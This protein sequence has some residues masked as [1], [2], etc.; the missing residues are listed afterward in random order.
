[1]DRKHL[2]GAIGSAGGNGPTLGLRRRFGGGVGSQF[3]VDWLLDQPNHP[4]RNLEGIALILGGGD[5]GE[6][7]GAVIVILDDEGVSRLEV[8]LRRQGRIGSEGELEGL[9][10]GFGDDIGDHR[11]GEIFLGLGVREGNGRREGEV[12]GG[13]HELREGAVGRLLG[14][15]DREGNAVGEFRLR[16]QGNV[17]VLI[18]GRLGDIGG[19]AGGDKAGGVIVAG[20]GDGMDGGER[21]DK[22]I[23]RRRAVNGDDDIDLFVNLRDVVIDN[24]DG[25]GGIGAGGALGDGD[26]RGYAVELDVGRISGGAGFKEGDG[27]L[28]AGGSGLAQS[29]SQCV[30]G[31][32]AGIDGIAG[33]RGG[34]ADVLVRV[35]DGEGVDELADG[36]APDTRE[37][38]GFGNGDGHYIFDI[39]FVLG[40]DER[41]DRIGGRGA[42]RDGIDVVGGVP[43]GVVRVV[44]DGDIAIHRGE[45]HHEGQ[46][47]GGGGGD[48]EGESD[49]V[50]AIGDMLIDCAFV[51][52]EGNGVVVGQ[53]G[54]GEGL[55]GIH[56]P[57]IDRPSAGDGEGDIDGL[58][59]FRA[60]GGV[61]IDNLDGDGGGGVSGH[62]VFGNGD[63]RGHAIETD[64]G[65]GVAGAGFG[66]G[67]GKRQINRR[68]LGEG[69][70]KVGG[71]AFAG[72]VQGR[73][74]EADGNVVDGNGETMGL[75][76]ADAPTGGGALAGVVQGDRVEGDGEGF[77]LLVEVVLAD[78]DGE[79]AGIRTSDGIGGDAAAHGEVIVVAAAGD[80]GG[81]GETL[82]GS[83]GVGDQ[84]ESDGAALVGGIRAG[85]RRGGEL[86]PA[87][88]GRDGDGVGVTTDDPAGG[89]VGQSGEGKDD[90]FG[91]F[92][93]IIG[94]QSDRDGGASSGGFQN[95]FGGGDFRV[96]PG[97]DGGAAGD[98][99]HH[100]SIGAGGFALEGVDVGGGDAHSEGIVSGGGAWLV[101]GGGGGNKADF[102]RRRL[103]IDDGESVL[104]CDKRPVGESAGAKP[105][106]VGLGGK[107]EDDILRPLHIGIAIDLMHQLAAPGILVDGDL[108]RAFRV[109]SAKYLAHEL[110]YIKIIAAVWAGFAHALGGAAA[111]AQVQDQILP[112]GFERIDIAGD[113][114]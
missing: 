56:Q 110:P 86:H 71:G 21:V 61:V 67:N 96:Q 52:G 48:V 59:L 102:P 97:A 34:K 98:G 43:I 26:G 84:G 42:G 90:G 78:V 53:N 12:G 3:E 65:S 13:I 79:G 25:D 88:V 68:C 55:G 27:Q 112:D 54:E 108:I 106:A 44:I 87:V 63:G 103:G 64:I 72:V 74:G 20:D 105:G 104:G 113:H 23:L 40:D 91:L 32:L 81:E 111:D 46:T 10:V 30:G 45:G 11:D 24:L 73:A 17:D 4:Q 107:G 7:E 62:R 69:Q 41:N 99:K 6:S 33:C 49:I 94:E 89:S 100:A 58:I 70:R 37:I 15:G 8:I 60:F 85:R 35:G 31:A 93:Q 19:A 9:L 16:L 22:P 18:G 47:G 14:G 92:D 57:P 50:A 77:V 66:D 76:G 2:H 114:I 39:V 95:H 51:G 75:V 5:F 36:F 29:Q 1:M 101:A 38:V 28:Q 109:G 82:G 80:R 83:N